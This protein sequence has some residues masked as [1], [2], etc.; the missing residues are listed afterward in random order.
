MTETA[1][2]AW[3]SIK[4]YAQT[5][6]YLAFV[7]GRIRGLVQPWV[8][9]D[10]NVNEIQRG[11]YIGDIASA[12][13][14]AKLKELGITHIITAVLGVGPQFPAS[15]EYLCVPVRDVH[16]EDIQSHLSDTTTFINNA[17]KSNGKVLVH[18][19]CGV[20]RSAT[21]VA[22]WVMAQ[23]GYTVAETIAMLQAQRP[24]VNPIPAFRE[25]LED[26]RNE[27]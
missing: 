19:V 23:N 27:N 10:F 5:S 6:Y 18:C 1:K 8:S 21:I 24:C 4:Y 2:W 13:N 15:F 11:V 14:E 12:Y 3:N 20:S 16:S 25:Q 9:T 22:A 7:Y 17:L 26:Y